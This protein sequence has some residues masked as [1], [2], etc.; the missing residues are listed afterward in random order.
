MYLYVL[1]CIYDAVPVK[2]TGIYVGLQIV[3]ID[4]SDNEVQLQNAIVKCSNISSLTEH[5]Q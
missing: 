3:M 4:A 1:I 2:F 5:I